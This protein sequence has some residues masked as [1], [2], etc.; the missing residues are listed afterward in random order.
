M[1][2]FKKLYHLLSTQE[3]KKAG[4]LLIMII[5][6]SLLDMLGVASIL[7]FMTVLA[8][9]GLIETN[10]VLNIMFKISSE[11][12]VETNQEFLFTLGILVFI[13]LIVSLAFKALTNYA[14]NLFVSMREHSIGKRLVEGYLHQ[15][16]SWFLNHHSA[17]LGKT[18]LSEVAQ[19]VGNGLYPVID[20]ISKS[21]ITIAIMTLLFFID[22]KLTLVVCLSFGSTYLLTFYIVQKLL[23][24][25]GKD[26]LNNNQLR[27]LAV[28]E[29]FGATKEVKAGGLEE[30]FIKK[31]S[32]STQIYARTNVLSQV[33]AI[34]P[35]YIF[36]AVAFGGILLILLYTKAQT[37]DFIN[38]LPII[39]LYAF[40]GYRL[41]PA[42]QQI[43]SALTQL[44]F[45]SPSIDKLNN[46][47]K[48][49]KV[50]EKNQDQVD[51]IFNKAIKLNKIYYN[52]PN[53]SRTSLNNVKLTIPARSTVGIIGQTG[54]GKTTMVDIILGLLEP[55]KGTLEVDEKIITRKNVRSWQRSIGYVPQSIFLSD[56]TVAANIAF[57]VDTKNIDLEAVKKASKIAN[58]H[59]FVKDEL[60]KQYQTKIG[61]NGV[62]LSGGQRQRIGVAR[63]LYHNPKVLIFDEA[64][65]ALD[66]Q[67]EKLI[68]G[69]I[70]NLKG[71]ITIILIAHR[72]D[73]L[74]NCDNIYLL[75]KGELKGQ[76]SFEDL[77]K[78]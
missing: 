64:T 6:M 8:N 13:L 74:K 14:Q 46:D 47:L 41:M 19:V 36:E 66:S 1:K 39:S 52:Y 59:E 62:R 71:D 77:A 10:I 25:I 21:I 50:H 43:Y 49:L 9:P 51:I 17:D 3:R 55:M 61:E 32:D 78:N 53:T 12:G 67:T 11:F 22:P 63:A 56:D 20:V 18:I 48:E 73:S 16:Y 40:A 72:L 38:S 75:D 5:I 45:V 54:C 69:A 60:P 76:R 70:N 68:M 65:S 2:I 27:F 24:Q 15:P 29:A 28:S 23:K 57:G 37:G 7:P 58:L 44:A 35:R 4:L 33:I 26:R 30:V 42:F 34:L 31:F